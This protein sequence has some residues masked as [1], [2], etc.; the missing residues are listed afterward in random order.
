MDRTDAFSRYLWDTLSG[1]PELDFEFGQGWHGDSYR[2]SAT[3]VD[4]LA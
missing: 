2:R 4:G 3:I 1:L